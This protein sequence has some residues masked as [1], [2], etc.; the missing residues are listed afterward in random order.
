VLDEMEHMGVR[1]RK[2]EVQQGL[3]AKEEILAGG[4]EVLEEPNS[5]VPVSKAV[6]QQELVLDFALEKGED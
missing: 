5:L 2:L 1:L 3:V 4:G 6:A